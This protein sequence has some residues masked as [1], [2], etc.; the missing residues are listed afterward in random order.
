MIGN[1]PPA[2]NAKN[3]LWPTKSVGST[4]INSTNGETKPTQ[5]LN[6]CEL[7]SIN[8]YAKNMLPMNCTS[9][10]IA[11]GKYTFYPY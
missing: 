5:S 8:E 10:T 9:V 7:T 1:I 4:P 11:N 3:L 2:K 6:D